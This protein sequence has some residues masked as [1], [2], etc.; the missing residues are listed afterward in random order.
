MSDILELQKL[1]S[2]YYSKEEVI[3]ISSL[4][5]SWSGSSDEAVNWLHKPIPAF[6]HMTAIEG[7]EKGL[8]EYIM[9]YLKQIENGGFA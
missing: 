9:T 6:G 8:S 1:L 7:C 2:P 5:M 4:L 3:Y